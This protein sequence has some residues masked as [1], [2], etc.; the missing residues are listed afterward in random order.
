MVLVNADENGQPVGCEH[1][2]ENGMCGEP[3]EYLVPDATHPGVGGDIEQ[4]PAMFCGE[5]LEGMLEHPPAEQSIFRCIVGPDEYEFHRPGRGILKVNP[6]PLA[7][8]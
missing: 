7:E 3:A 5:P 1:E 8:E 2:T 6:C 4:R